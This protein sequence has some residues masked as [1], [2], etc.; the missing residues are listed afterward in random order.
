MT[1]TRRT[2]RQFE[3]LKRPYHRDIDGLLLGTKIYVF[4]KLDGTN[5]SV[6][7]DASTNTVQT[8]SR[9]RICTPE[10]DNAGFSAWVN[11]DDPKAAWLRNFLRARQNFTIYGEWLVPHTFKAYR[12]EAWR[13]FWIFDVYD[14]DENRYLSLEEYG[15]MLTDAEN[16]DAVQDVIDP[17]AIYDHPTVDQIYTEV[18]RNTYLVQDNAGPGEG[19]VVKNYSWTNFHGC[20]PWMKIVRTEFKERNQKV[21]GTTEEQGS[22]S[23]EQ[24]I[25]DDYLTQEL[26]NQTRAK[27]VLELANNLKIDPSQDLDREVSTTHRGKLIPMLLSRVQH[28]LISENAWAFVKKYGKHGPIDFRVLQ[29]MCFARTKE[30][31]SDLF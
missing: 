8:G 5:A 15:P 23:V 25:V 27:S 13:R 20:Q 29:S 24:A 10:K 30:M 28:D 3:S 19:V 17:L 2:F 22:F 9:R 7:W 11:G 16:P 1:T 6:W 21:F 4:P 12:E 14:H 18:E 26:V 31:A